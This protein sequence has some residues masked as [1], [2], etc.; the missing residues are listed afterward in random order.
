MHRT[1]RL[2]LIACMVLIALL[3][4]AHASSSSRRASMRRLAQAMPVEE[5][6][7]AELVAELAPTVEAAEAVVPESDSAAVESAASS[8]E[9][10][11]DVVD[12]PKPDLPTEEPIVAPKRGAAKAKKVEQPAAPADAPAAEQKVSGTEKVD[13]APVAAA[14]AGAVEAVVEQLNKEGLKADDKEQDEKFT[15]TKQAP[16]EGVR[17]TKDLLTGKFKALPKV[18][19]T[20]SSAGSTSS[21]VVDKISAVVAAALANKDATVGTVNVRQGG[22]PSMAHHHRHSGKMNFKAVMNRHNE[23]H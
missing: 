4:P 20:R 2:L 10:V 12:A 14:K 22:G 19:P 21:G 16:K 17:L 13:S 5:A 3:I 7:Q 23:F 8:T 1:T 18:G 9:A 6:T 15:Q 11:V